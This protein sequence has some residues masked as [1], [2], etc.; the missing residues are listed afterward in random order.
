MMS[1]ARKGWT[2]FMQ[3]DD[4]WWGAKELQVS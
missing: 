1:K 3:I 2:H 4:L